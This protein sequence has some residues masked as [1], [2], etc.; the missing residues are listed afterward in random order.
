MKTT[1][2]IALL[3]GINVGGNNIIKMV[4]LKSCFQ[5]MGFTEVTTY[6]Q[7]GNVIFKSSEEDKNILIE[8]IEQTLSGKFQYRSKI[9]LITHPF[10]KNVLENAP[11]DFGTSPDLYRYD[12]F[13]IKESLSA[14][15]VMESVQIRE[16]VDQAHQDNGVIY[17]TRLISKA[18]QS[19]LNQ[20]IKIKIYKE[21]T[22]RNYNTT[23]K[24]LALIEK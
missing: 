21:I 4:D 6:I 15:K 1:T 23:S 2:Y 24:L 13:F 17:F 3:R 19:Y 10:L 11:K 16:G 18:G 9:V 5:S 12:V 22:V 8:K 20:L 7:S 14:K